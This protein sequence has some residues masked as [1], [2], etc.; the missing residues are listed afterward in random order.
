MNFVAALLLS[1]SKLFSRLYRSGEKMLSV[2]VC[3]GWC[4]TELARYVNIP[5]YKKVP[6]VEAMASLAVDLSCRLGA[7]TPLPHTVLEKSCGRHWF[8]TPDSCFI[9]SDP[10]L[11]VQIQFRYGF[12]IEKKRKLDADTLH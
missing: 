5:L 9:F 11:L 12:E 7:M 4:S 3:P 10:E 2:C 8:S 1:S 6:K